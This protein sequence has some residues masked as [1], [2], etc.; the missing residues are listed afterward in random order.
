MFCG[1]SLFATYS[2]RAISSPATAETAVLSSD[3]PGNGA[4]M[5]PERR[6]ALHKKN[7]NETMA[8]CHNVFQVIERVEKLN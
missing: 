6:R 1:I 4:A 2:T 5:A 8:F 3:S 7:V